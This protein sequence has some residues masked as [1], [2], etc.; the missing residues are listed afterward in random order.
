MNN[1]L[2]N[3]NH[4]H[5]PT[6]AKVSKANEILF[7]HK[8]YSKIEGTKFISGTLTNDRTPTLNYITPETFTSEQI[9]LAENIIE[10]LPS[11]K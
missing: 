4:L 7:E 10:S 5:L 9:A 2:N 6:D 3:L 8:D 1:F 11:L